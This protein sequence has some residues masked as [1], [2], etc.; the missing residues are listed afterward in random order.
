MSGTVV[1]VLLC[2]TTCLAVVSRND[3]LTTVL[4]DVVTRS[5]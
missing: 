5:Y 4:C 1:S 3:T 2:F